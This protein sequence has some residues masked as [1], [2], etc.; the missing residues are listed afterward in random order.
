[1][2]RGNARRSSLKELDR[3]I[4]NQMSSRTVSKETLGK[5]LRDV[6]ERI[7]AFPST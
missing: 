3:A 5:F 6:L 7:W 4:V 1:M 2:E